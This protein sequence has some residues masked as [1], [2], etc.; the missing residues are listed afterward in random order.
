MGSLSPGAPEERKQ[1]AGAQ[2]DYDP[3]EGDQEEGGRRKSRA[4]QTSQEVPSLCDPEA[5]WTTRLRWTPGL[6][7]RAA[8]GV[9]RRHMSVTSGQADSAQTL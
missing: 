6:L 9:M 3:Q 5:A 8:N 1:A 4:Q 2:A 7:L